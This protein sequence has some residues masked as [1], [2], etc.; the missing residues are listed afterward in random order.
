M[1]ADPAFRQAFA[2]TVPQAWLRDDAVLWAVAASLVLHLM[3][4]GISLVWRSIPPLPVEVGVDV[5]ML[6]PEEFEAATGVSSEPANR[7]P[8]ATEPRAIPPPPAADTM[9]RPTRM[10]SAAALAEPGSRQAREMLG[11]ID[12]TERS[13]QLCGFEAIEQVRAWNPDIKPERFV[14]YALA[15]LAIAGD[16]IKGGG[17]AFF[18]GG[19]WYAMRFGCGLSPDHKRVTSFEFQVGDPVPRAHWDVHNLPTPDGGPDAD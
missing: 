8:P 18:A 12:A 9:V 1:Q 14:A 15:D 5:Q 4:F 7:P 6:T 17:A 13:I 16:S 19:K 10:L 11:Q 2:A 3:L